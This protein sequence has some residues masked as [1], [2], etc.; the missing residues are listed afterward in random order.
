MLAW[1]LRLPLRELDISASPNGDLREM[2]AYLT[3]RGIDLR[4]FD[5]RVDFDMPAVLVMAKARVDCGQWRAGGHIVSPN[6][7]ATWED[8][9]CHGVQEILG[10]Y[11]AFALVSPDGDPAVDPASGE[12]RLWWP[13]FAAYFKPRADE[14][15]SFLG[16]GPVQAMPVDDA[17]TSVDVFLEGLKAKLRER[18]LRAYVRY[19]APEAVVQSG[20]VAVRVCVPGLVR[21]TASRDTVNFGERRIE[22]IRSRWGAAPGL[23]PLPHPIS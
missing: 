21:M 3:A 22:Q 10:H 2:H 17:P 4:A 16:S 20:L 18:H 23:N 11:S 5:M 6:V 9:A 15:F 19:L 7:A 12:T 13:N 8:A 1:Y 14:P